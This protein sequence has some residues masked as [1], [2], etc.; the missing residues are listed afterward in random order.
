MQTLTIEVAS[1]QEALAQAI[2]A[3][4]S[5]QPLPPRYLFDSDEALLN[6]LSGN[7][8]AILKALSRAGAMSIAELARCMQR[9]R[10]EVRADTERLRA[11]GL[12]DK[13][14]SCDL[15]FPYTGVLLE[16]CWRSDA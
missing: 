10:A 4:E 5:N 9:D 7:R 13:T 16:L 3:I 8:F 12:I 2:A 11:I 15:H 1:E 6:T 14:E